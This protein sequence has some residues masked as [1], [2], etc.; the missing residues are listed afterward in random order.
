CWAAMTA[1]GLA[2]AVSASPVSNDVNDMTER[3]AP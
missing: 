3:S 2:A 1:E